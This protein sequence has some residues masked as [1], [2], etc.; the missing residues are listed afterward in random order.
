MLSEV[1][2][3]I[4]RIFGTV[5]AR[6]TLLATLVVGVAL[7]GASVL[8]VALQRES[9][10]DNV[11]ATIHLRAADVASILAS[12]SSPGS[13]T[14]SDDEIALVQVL[15]SAGQIVG[16]S[17]NIS[18]V[19]PV[20]DDR[21]PPGR[22][23]TRQSVEIP[24]DDGPFRVIA[25][26]VA[27]PSGTY[28]ILVAGSLEDVDESIASLIGLLRLGI[29]MLMLVVAVGAWFLV[30]RALS[31]VETIR[32]EVAG[33]GGADLSRRVPQSRSNDEIARLARTMNEMLARIESAYAR[34][35]EFVADAAHEL[36]SPLATMR[37]QLEVDF[38]DLEDPAAASTAAE[39]HDEVLRMQRLT[40]DLL[41][42]ARN[43]TTG[44]PRLDLVDLDDL[45][46]DEARRIG[47]T[48]QVEISTSGV[49]A[50]Q[51]RGDPNRLGR[52]LRNVIENA[53]RHARTRVVIVLTE[54]DG[55]AVLAITDDGPGI[56]TAEQE[57]IFERFARID[58]ARGRADGGAGLGLAITRT[59]LD[60]HGGSID[61][62]A[63]HAG[64]AR[65]VITIP[66]AGGASGEPRPNRP[67]S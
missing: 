13:V 42:L 59:I 5:R 55:L 60:A 67:T 58:A 39:L 54:H 1:A 10:E 38:A 35:D 20:I 53:A 57:R 21:P 6:I 40:D 34:Q 49:S 16:A 47:T 18:D 56:P 11:D 12:G 28:T 33:I 14:V 3:R 22:T 50:A 66:C 64:G 27:T 31:P 51:V 24:V 26:T 25:R 9:L 63:R 62:D 2:R 36:R 37:A 4:A 17:P 23:V 61:V 15:D 29:P 52:A 43:G 46:L 44:T 48:G 7:V 32:R 19:Q 65:F 45:V 8:L 30:G 41:L